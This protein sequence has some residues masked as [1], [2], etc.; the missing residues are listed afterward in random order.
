MHLVRV[1]KLHNLVIT[2]MLLSIGQSQNADKNK[3][4]NLEL[5]FTKMLK[6]QTELRGL[7]MMLE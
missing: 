7:N 2:A 6:S 4:K 3:E 1:Q 5:C